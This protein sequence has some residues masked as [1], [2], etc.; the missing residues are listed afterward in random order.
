MD[1]K[2]MNGKKKCN[3]G[4]QAQKIYKSSDIYIIQSFTIPVCAVY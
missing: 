4:I 1:S 3:K 2:Y